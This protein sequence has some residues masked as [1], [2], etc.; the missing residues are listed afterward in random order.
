[1]I[2]ICV[3]PLEVRDVLSDVASLLNSQKLVVS[4]AGDVSLGKLQALCPARLARAFPSMASEKL[5]G[6]TLLA[7]GDNATAED[8]QLIAGLFNAIG[9]AVEI[10]EKDFDVLADLTSSAPGYFAALMRESCWQQKEGGSRLSWLNAWSS[11][12]CLA[13]PCSWR[14]KALP[15]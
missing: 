4:V 8:R 7:F 1:M 6:V 11:R 10:E 12:P 14:K 5:Q 15:G 13:R 3:R 2:F 9:Q